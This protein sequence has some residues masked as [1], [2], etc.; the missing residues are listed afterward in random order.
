MRKRISLLLALTILMGCFAAAHADGA[1]I[2]YADEPGFDTPEAALVSYVEGLKNQDL[3]QMLN[4]FG[5]KTQAAHMSFL[6]TL[7][8]T[9]AYST[10]ICPAFPEGLAVTDSLNAEIARSRAVTSLKY[11][12]T[13][14]VCPSVEDVTMIVPI[15]KNYGT[16]E[17]FIASVVDMTRLDMLKTI[18]N[19]QT[20]TPEEAMSKGYLAPNYFSERNLEIIEKNRLMY[21]ADEL[22]DRLVT[23]SMGQE[24]YGFAPAVAR[25][26]DRWYLYSMSG[27]GAMI[28]GISATDA[29]FFSITKML[30][31]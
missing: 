20:Y 18:D 3:D 21:G 8:R 16:A 24:L 17:S 5:F 14:L 23:F 26:G 25:F 13:R 28:M 30:S 19:I 31:R 15:S 29:A 10:S 6:R 7:D 9:G 12:F 4:A 22:A 1:F 11:A 2:K 27:T